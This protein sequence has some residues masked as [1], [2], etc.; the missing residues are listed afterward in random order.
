MG[1]FV[2]RCNED[3]CLRFACRKGGSASTARTPKPSWRRAAAATRAMVDRMR[4]EPWWAGIEALA[5]TLACDP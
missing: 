3:G 2:P 1:A 5:P 4:K